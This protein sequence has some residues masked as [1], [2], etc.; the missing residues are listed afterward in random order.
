MQP[1]NF[2]DPI[3]KTKT[4]DFLTEFDETVKQT[5][6][7]K[8]N[9]DWKVEMSRKQLK[10]VRLMEPELCLECRFAQTADV[11]TESGVHQR[12]IYCRR[13]DCDNWD[14]VNAEPAKSME[15]DDYGLDNAA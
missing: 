15:V 1:G 10:I 6:R 11:E 2:D 9:L 12:M 7:R 14:I 5:G 3:R 8:S 4:D 13:L